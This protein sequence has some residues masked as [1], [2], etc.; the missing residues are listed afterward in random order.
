MSEMRLPV[1]PICKR[2]VLLPLSTWVLRYGREKVIGKWICTNC[3]FYITTGKSAGTDLEDITTD[4]HIP[5]R[6][7]IEYLRREYKK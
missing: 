4:F 5:L 2:E 7:R 1:C 3:G 6:T